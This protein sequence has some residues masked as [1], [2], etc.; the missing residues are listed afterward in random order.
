MPHGLE[1]R[2]DPLHL[3][4]W[5]AVHSFLGR[6]L[7]PASREIG[8]GHVIVISEVKPLLVPLLVGRN[9]FM[10]MYSLDWE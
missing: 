6:I 4:L 10:G 5:G 3:Q 8:K 9:P 2:L 7:V 1:E